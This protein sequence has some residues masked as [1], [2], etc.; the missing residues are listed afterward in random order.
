MVWIWRLLGVIL[1]HFRGLARGRFLMYFLNGPFSLPGRF[2][3]AR[4]AQKGAKMSPKATKKVV[5]RRSMECVKTMAVTVREPYGRVPGGAR[6]PLFSGS[7]RE[8]LSEGFPRG[9]R[10]DF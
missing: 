8:G 3:G 2:L 1:E 6:E 4:G 5:R 10:A 7:W 9:A